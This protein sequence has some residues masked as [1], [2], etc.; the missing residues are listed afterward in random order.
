MHRNVIT[1]KQV[2]QLGKWLHIGHIEEDNLSLMSP[3][4]EII[5]IILDFIQEPLYVCLQAA[6]K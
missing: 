5:Q 6:F 1:Q 3:V 2:A 4:L